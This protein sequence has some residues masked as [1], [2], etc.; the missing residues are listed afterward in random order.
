MQLIANDICQQL[1]KNNTIIIKGETG[2][3]KSTL[4][5]AVFER[6]Q[7]LEA[8][9]GIAGILF[10]SSQNNTQR[11]AFDSFK[12]KIHHF[13]KNEVRIFYPLLSACD[14]YKND[15]AEPAFINADETKYLIAK[16]IDN[17]RSTEL[18]FCEIIADNAQLANQIYTCMN[19]CIL[20]DVQPEI[21]MQRYAQC[22]S[23]PQPERLN[24]LEH[25][26]HVINRYRLKCVENGIFDI[27]T[28]IWY[29]KNYILTNP[30]YVSNFRDRYDF[31][32]FDDIECLSVIEAQIAKEWSNIA[33]GFCACANISAGYGTHGEDMIKYV[34]DLFEDKG[35]FIEINSNKTQ[36]NKLHCFAD[37]FYNM[38]LYG[39]DDLQKSRHSFDSVIIRHKQ[40]QF[41]NEMIKNAAYRI[42]EIVK[43]ENIKP[44]DICVLTSY[45]D[46]VTFDDMEAYLSKEG[47]RLSNDM[48]FTN[49]EN[50]PLVSILITLIR[51][52]YPHMFG[53]PELF[54][55]NGL[56]K[57]L[58]CNDI[59]ILS[60]ISSIVSSRI[61]NR[62]VLPLELPL[63]E[64]EKIQN[65]HVVEDYKLFAI[66]INNHIKEQK[67]C[68]CYNFFKDA[69]ENIIYPVAV[70]RSNIKKE[71]IVSVK[72][73]LDKVENFEKNVSLFGQDPA[74]NVFEYLTKWKKLNT[75]PEEV[76]TLD[77]NSA[78]LTT[79]QLF[80]KSSFMPEVL[81]VLAISSRN[82]YS[83][84][85]GELLHPWTYNPYWIDSIIYNEVLEEETNKKRMADLFRAVFK[86]V[87]KRIELFES[88]LSINLQPNEGMLSEFFDVL[89]KV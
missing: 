15:R 49:I 46:P 89:S 85:A 78:R 33:K 83:R 75:M 58:F 65:M 45:A 56:L 41:R 60:A 7:R 47:I 30:I 81:I 63:S 68:G 79:P 50:I 34:L 71:D 57:F 62:T 84:N 48:K 10:F 88:K 3:G 87:N 43:N 36:H 4:I 73:F 59:R 44:G 31:I 18:K 42:I 19:M 80:L 38:I 86:K 32:L 70:K 17:L 22:F 69:F 6:L 74:K 28:A 54:K 66:W 24:M 82:W 13:I 26:V 77:E 9:T 8:H 37:Y 51:M 35:V 64:G 16:V 29:Y 40:T 72:T 27:C 39:S 25:A 2:S 55:L 67:C 1:L 53:I 5:E 76:Q 21:A 52:A 23:M 12:R 14:I 11:S 61:R 20:F